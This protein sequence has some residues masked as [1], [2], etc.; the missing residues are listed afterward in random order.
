LVILVILVGG[1]V[2]EWDGSFANSLRSI[3]IMCDILFINEL[4]FF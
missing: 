1:E 2:A 3:L 4:F